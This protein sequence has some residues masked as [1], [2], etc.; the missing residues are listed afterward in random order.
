VLR[1]C[2]I[3][4]TC[5]VNA[6]G[7]EWWLT[8]ESG[9]RPV[10]CG[11]HDCVVCSAADI[12]DVS[13]KGYIVV[14]I[15]CEEGSEGVV[16]CELCIDGFD[17]VVEHIVKES[18]ALWCSE[19]GRWVDRLA[20]LLCRLQRGAYSKKADCKCG[21]VAGVCAPCQ[22]VKRNERRFVWRD[23]FDGVFPLG[24]EHWFSGVTDAVGTVCGG[25]MPWLFCWEGTV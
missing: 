20:E 6:R 13:V 19:E 3:S 11:Q 1:E 22:F 2:G 14:K 16:I 23:R 9:S 21:M 24:K 18:A 12:T 15:T 4:L 8:R 17:I 5:E 25:Y 10:A 7:T